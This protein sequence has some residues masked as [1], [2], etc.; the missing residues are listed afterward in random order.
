M[1]YIAHV[2]GLRVCEHHEF[3]I[4]WRLI[5]VQL[6]LASPVGYETACPIHQHISRHPQTLA[7]LPV[8]RPPKLSHHIAQGEYGP[9]YELSIVLCA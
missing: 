6:I 1:Q 8:I 5:V 3:D 2:E 4:R 9:E 7:S